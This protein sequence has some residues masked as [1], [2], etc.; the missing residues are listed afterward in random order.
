MVVASLVALV[1]ASC[2]VSFN[3][4]STVESEDK[5]KAEQEKFK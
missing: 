3:R 1:V 2:Q 5:V 4:K